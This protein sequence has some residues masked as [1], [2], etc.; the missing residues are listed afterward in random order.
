MMALRDA[1]EGLHGSI[2]HRN[3]LHNVDSVFNELLAEEIKLKSHS[4]LISDKGVLS[5]PSSI[6]AAPFH[7]GRPQGRVGL[8]IDECA[9][10]KEKGFGS[11]STPNLS[12]SDVYY[13][14]KPT[15]TDVTATPDTDIPLVPMTTQEPSTTVDP[16]LPRYPSCDLHW[17][18]VLRTCHY[19]RGTQFQSLLFPSSSSLELHAYFDADWVGDPRDQAK[20]RAIISITTRIVWLRRL[21]FDMDVILSKPTP[22]DCDNKS[23]T[24]IA[25]NSVFHEHTKYI[26]IDCHFTHHHLE[27]ETITILLVSSALQIVDLFTK[28][29]SIKHFPSFD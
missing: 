13:I 24:Q 26:E 22:M 4:N 18:V 12:F 2:M 1:F 19:I 29:H 17:A 11:I 10:C 23:V 3:P 9:F 14:P 27:H 16:Q 28:T 21:L 6:F 7:K 15:L 5:T 20:Y 8:S 25:Y